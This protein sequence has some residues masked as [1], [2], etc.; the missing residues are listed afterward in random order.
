MTQTNNLPTLP[1]HIQ[2]ID[3]V[4]ERDRPLYERDDFVEGYSL[5]AAARQ[6]RVLRAAVHEAGHSS[7]SLPRPKPG[8]EPTLS[9]R[10]WMIVLG[11]AQPNERKVLLSAAG[12]G[13][14]RV[15]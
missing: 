4:P 5:I 8:K 11:A 15:K 12:R 9:R 1:T 3:A 2:T 13:E 6:L 14:L 10:E 7:P